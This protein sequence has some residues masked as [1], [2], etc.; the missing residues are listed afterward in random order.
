[1]KYCKL[2]LQPDTRPNDYFTDEGICVAC[3]NY[4]NNMHLDYSSRFRLLKDIVEKHDRTPGQFFDCIIG[5]SGGKDSTRQAL[6]VRDK[7]GLKPL[8]V[9]L[10]YPPHQVSKLGVDNMSNLIELGFDVI[11]SSPS[12]E[13]WRKLVKE[14]FLKFSNWARATEIALYSSIPK[15]SLHYNIP[16][17]F[18]GENQSFRDQKTIDK[19]GWI[20]N[21]MVN[22]NTL[23]GGDIKW[24]NDAGF[25][26]NAL[27]PYQYPS[28]NKI[29][30]GNI[31]IIDLGWFI[32]DWDNFTNSMMA[33]SNGIEIRSDTIENTGDP[34]G[35][36]AL[37]EDWVTLNQMIKYYKFG[38]GKVTDYVNEDIRLGRLK[39]SE[40]VEFV[41]KYDGACAD[42]YI[43]S[44]CKYID[45]TVEEFW[46]Q[47]H[48]NV[49]KKLFTIKPDG[50]I[51]RKFKVGVG[52]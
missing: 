10:S 19:D 2:C 9:S 29:N 30:K 4:N 35:T 36:S 42:K 16:L 8:L 52:L 46:G 34:M 1:M 3:K 27:I 25:K 33:C 32:G 15:I 37:D 43:E 22:Q 26:N 51:Q 11:I 47:V 13:T 44:F 50:S 12:P 23:N 49:N 21:N 5:V 24:M 14:A 17:I 18:V 39:R 28:M 45:I 7:L 41:T 6:W 31:E 20:Y 38:F 40:C 48:K